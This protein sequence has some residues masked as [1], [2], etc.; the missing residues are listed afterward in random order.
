MFKLLNGQRIKAIYGGRCVCSAMDTEGG[1]IMILQESYDSLN[2]EIKPTK[3]PNNEMPIKIACCNKY[4][5]VLS[6]SGHVFR[7]TFPKNGVLDFE[8]VKEISKEKIIDISTTFHHC[9]VVNDKGKVLGIGNNSY[10]ILGFPKK[11]KK[12]DKFTEVKSLKKF[13]IVEAYAGFSH[14]LFKTNDGKIIS[15]GMNSCG[16]MLIN[17]KAVVSHFS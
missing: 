14:S 3:L 17:R 8:Q 1:I 9:F 6:S 13:K 5:N 7:S 12:V 2:S 15:I 16:E 4:V 10:S 11:V